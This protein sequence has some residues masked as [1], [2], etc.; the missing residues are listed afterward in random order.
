[1]A[2]VD[3]HLRRESCFNQ[4]FFYVC[5]V[6]SAV[7]WLF[8]AAQNNMAIAITAGIH[9]RRMTPFGHGQ[10]AVWRSCGVDCINRDF[11][12]AIGTV[13]KTNRARQTRCQLAMYLGLSGTRPDRAPTHQVGEVLRR[14]HVE[15]FTRSRQS[16]VVDIQ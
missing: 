15:E 4:T 11:D 5:D 9:D 14:D 6:L 16:A 8:A 13:F 10:E 1:M 3:H 12:R 2:K 7:I